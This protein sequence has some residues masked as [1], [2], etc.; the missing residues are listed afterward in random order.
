M[1]P[2]LSSIQSPQKTTK[3]T[4]LFSYICSFPLRSL[5]DTAAYTGAFKNEQW[6]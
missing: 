5:L 3:Y 4:P 6:R 1:K 2:C